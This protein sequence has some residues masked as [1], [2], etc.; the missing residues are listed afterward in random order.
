MLSVTLCYPLFLLVMLSA[1]LAAAASDELRFQ[2]LLDKAVR[3]GLPGVSLS[4]RGPGID[5]AAAAGV[6]DVLTGE[7]LTVNHRIYMASLGKTLTASLAL[8]L[9]DES[10]LNLDAPV[11][12]WLPERVTGRIPMSA[13][14]TLRH[15]LGHR[16]GLS[17]YMNDAVAWRNAFVS[18]PGR[19]WT[20]GDIVSYLYDEP[21]FFEPG[22]KFEYSNS[23]YI[24]AGMIIEAATGQ[25]LHALIRKRLLDPLGMKYTINGDE[26]ARDEHNARGYVIR[27]GR[28]I[29]TY[30]WFGHYGLADSG[31]LSTPRDMTLFAESLFSSGKVLSRRM[32][33]EMTD[34]A[35]TGRS[36]SSYG[37]GIYVQQNPWGAGL[38][39]YSHD[40][41]DP[42]YQADLLYQPDYELSI[43]LA[44]NAGMGKVDRVYEEL[45]ADVVWSALK[46]VREYR[47]A[48]K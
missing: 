7:P 24:L 21:L 47:S 19:R 37:L 25:P 27:R 18:D 42:G 33:G 12:R 43:V 15:L 20:H 3:D 40:G 22:S 1:S 48:C 28:I 6:A 29:D 30:P 26:R 23:N 16:S 32:L 34:V 31:I 39:W 46:A 17:D 14:I 41:I 45:L 2:S 4:I 9:Y 36:G 5:F 44:A 10:R 35:M 11:T 13:A 8:Q 38:R